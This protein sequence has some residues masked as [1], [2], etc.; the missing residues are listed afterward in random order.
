MRL[1]NAVEKISNAILDENKV[2]T[3]IKAIFLKGSLARNTEDK[4]SN[5]DLYCIIEKDKY[6]FFLEKEL[7]ILNKYDVIVYSKL[8]KNHLICVFEDGVILNLYTLRENELDFYD[9]MIIFY[10]PSGILSNYEKI[11]LEYSLNEIGELMDSFLLT[12]LHFY[13]AY[14]REDIIYSFYLACTLFKDLGIFIRIK[15]DPEYAKLGLKNLVLNTENAT[16]S[17]EKYLDIARKLKITS[18]LEC[19][20]M[21]YVLLDHY[22]NNIPILLAEYINFDF[23]AYSKRKIMSIN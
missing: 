14:M 18:V 19:V 9:D 3:I 20:K 23:Y 21:I 5:I 13:N 16:R 2:E 7:I 15:Y 22:V 17:R 4:Y 1:Y 10:D 6:D 12:S 11:P 8:N